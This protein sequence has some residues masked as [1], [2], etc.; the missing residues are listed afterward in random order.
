MSRTYIHYAPGYRKGNIT[1]ISR[2]EKGHKWSYRCD[3]GFEG[4]TQVSENPGFCPRCSRKHVAE[5]ATKHGESPDNE[6]NASRLYSI[7]LN[8]K[9]RCHNP[10]YKAFKYYGARGITVCDE[11]RHDYL[12]FKQWALENGYSEELTI[13]RIDVNGNY[14]PSNCRWTTWS[15]Q[16]NNKRNTKRFELNGVLYTL[17]ELSLL[18]G[19][20]YHTIKGRLNRYGWSVEDAVSI[21]ARHGNNQTLR[22]KIT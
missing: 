21:P 16:C 13:D 17:K 5:R 2:L 10:K 9:Q 14:E 15:V 1:L 6:K 12:A 20:D 19:I 7:W 11:W 18:S 3:C 22:R 8:M 4:V